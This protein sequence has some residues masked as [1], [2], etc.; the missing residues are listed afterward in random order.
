MTE[1]MLPS[2]WDLG[3]L[4]KFRRPNVNRTLARLER[5]HTIDDLRDI[6]KSGDTE[7]AVR[8]H[9]RRGRGRDVAGRARQAFEDIEFHPSILRDVSDGR[10][11]VRRSR[12]P[13]GDAV[14]DRADRLHPHDADRGRARR[15]GGR[16]CGRHP[17]LAVDDGHDAPEDVAEANPD[18]RN[19]FQLYMWKDRD[20]LDG[21]GATERPT[22][23]ST[24]CWSPSTS[25]SPVPDCAT[26]TT[27]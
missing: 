1:R 5:A 21:R 9:R 27:V 17:V 23:A 26:G 7:G 11:I 4:L 8:L 25:R 13:V 19:W 22:P 10:H 24:P 12:W 14:R 18:G 20:R 2:P 6:A 3:D 16:G 15:R